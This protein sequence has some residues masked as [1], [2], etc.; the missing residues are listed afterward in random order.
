M[1][2]GVMEALMSALWFLAFISF[3]NMFYF[4]GKIYEDKHVRNSFF[5][6]LLPTFIVTG[7]GLTISGALYRR[8]FLYWFALTAIMFLICFV[9]SFVY[10]P[11]LEF[12]F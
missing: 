6:K 7:K 10:D 12:P 4:F 5:R 2:F 8:K 3:A 1:N 11:D 9:A